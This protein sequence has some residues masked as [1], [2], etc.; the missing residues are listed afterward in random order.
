MTTYTGASAVLADVQIGAVRRIIET[1]VAMYENR[2]RHARTRADR[3]ELTA[4]INAL[5]LVLQAMRVIE[6]AVA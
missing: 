3:G 1:D 5:H 6:G 2:R 4:A